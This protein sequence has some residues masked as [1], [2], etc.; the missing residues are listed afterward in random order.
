[1]GCGFN[2]CN[3]EMGLVGDEWCSVSCGIWCSVWWV[4]GGVWCV[5]CVCGE[6]PSVRS[7]DR[8]T[9]QQTILKNCK[10]PI[11]R[12]CGPMLDIRLYMYIYIRIYMYISIY[13]IYIL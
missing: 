13:I 1:M 3:L 5:V 11:N 2:G 4:V 10:L 7:I 12:F 6:K 9:S 8:G